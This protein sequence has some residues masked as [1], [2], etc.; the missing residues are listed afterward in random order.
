MADDLGAEALPHTEY[1]IYNASP[2]SHGFRRSS[3][4]NAFATPVCSPTRAMI[5]TG[6]YP[7]RTGIMERMDSRLDPDKN[8]RLPSH[9][10][11]LGHM[12]Q[13]AGYATA[14]AGK[15]H[16]GDFQRYP[17][18]PTSHGFDEH[19]LWVQYWDGK[20]PSRY[21]GPHNWENG[22]YRAHSKEVYGPDFYCDFLL[23]FI[24]RNRELP[25]FAYFPYE[26]NSRALNRASRPTGT[27]CQLIPRRSWS[28][29]ANY[30]P[31]DYLYGCHCR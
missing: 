29:R 14:I 9:I 19:C 28:Q 3:F 23:D 5:L 16:L 4:R 27:R 25:F 24:E 7:N 2:R 8:N 17:D 22:E 11:T 20:R 6:L 13:E 1:G 21:Y 15:W 26:S 10:K 31:Y 12:F 30:W 18:Q